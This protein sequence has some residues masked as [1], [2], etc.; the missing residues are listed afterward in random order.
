MRVSS[1][2]GKEKEEM[3]EWEYLNPLL[4][5]PSANMLATGHP[6]APTTAA[7]AATCEQSI[8]S[9]DILVVDRSE[10]SSL[11]NL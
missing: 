4:F 1:R 9:S 8:L 2:P 11:S 10:V 5:S 7:A 6:L 3:G